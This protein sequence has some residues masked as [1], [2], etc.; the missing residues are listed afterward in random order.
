MANVPPIDYGPLKVTFPSNLPRNEKDLICM[1]LAGRLKDLWKGKLVCAQLALDDLIKDTTGISALGTLRANLLAA[2]SALGTFKQQ[3]GYDKILSGVN[4]AM[5]QMS[6]VFS[7]GGLCPSPITPPNIPD[8]LGM[9]NQNLFGQANNILNALVQAS[10]PKACLGGGPKGFGLDWSKV[11]GDLKVLKNAIN[12]FKNNPGA[13]QFVMRSFESN[14]AAQ[15]RRL[16]SEVKRLKSNLT[17]PLGI[18]D[19][20]N[21]AGGIK[22]TNAISGDVAVKNRN[23][24]TLKSPLAGMLTGETEH[25]LSRNDPLYAAPVTYKTYPVL[26]YCGDVTGYERKVVTG[27]PNYLG[28]D[29][30]KPE[31]NSMMPTEFPDTTTNDYDYSFIETD[32]IVRLYDNKDQE[33]YDLN[34]VR[35]AHYRIKLELSSSTMSFRNANSNWSSGIKLTKHPVYGYQFEIVTVDSTTVY[36]HRSIEIDWEVNIENPTTPDHLTWSTSSGQSG[37]IYVTGQSSINEEDKTYDI[38]QALKKGLLFTETYTDTFQNNS[39]LAER[40]NTNDYFTLTS[41]IVNS[42]S[43]SINKQNEL[44]CQHVDMSPGYSVPDQEII[45]TANHYGI[46]PDTETLGVDGQPIAG[47]KILKIVQSVDSRYLIIKLYINETDGV[48][49]KQLNVYLTNNLSNETDGYESLVNLIYTDSMYFFNDTK[50]PSTNNEEY[51]LTLL[52]DT[53]TIDREDVTVEKINDII[54]FNLSSK[55]QP[56]E[57][58]VSDYIFRFDIKIDLNDNGR[59][60]VTTNPKLNNLYFYFKGENNFMIEEE[61][62]YSHS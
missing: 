52:T 10:N 24:V 61:F 15:T 50:L 59:T 46:I 8:V 53:K 42:S 62:G 32:G 28:W 30:V 35:G 16:N 34:L 20:K 43:G 12:E 39:F 41:N 51:M 5:G 7:L 29:T 36:D 31:L 54:R 11:T 23:G 3:S 48:D 45:I 17:D 9:L 55:R 2:K 4:Q 14:L 22:R 58:S 18:N 57:L 27:D 49:I 44:T 25:V 6:N 38:S 1:L 40:G 19:S 47:N 21:I 33:I 37:N 13:Y 56:S 60:Y 26:D